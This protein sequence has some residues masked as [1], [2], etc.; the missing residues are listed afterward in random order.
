MAVGRTKRL[1][2][3]NGQIP[4]VIARSL[5]FLTMSFKAQGVA[6]PK[7]SLERTPY[8]QIAK[9]LSLTKAAMAPLLIASALKRPVGLP[10][11]TT[12]ILTDRR[13]R[14]LC[15]PFRLLPWLK[16]QMWHAAPSSRRALRTATL[17]L[18]VRTA[19]SGMKKK[20]F[21]PIPMRCSSFL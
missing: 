17:L 13:T 3:R 15:A 5:S 12:D 4:L 10:R 6:P 21:P 8:P 9:Q 20:L 19:L 7:V 18:T 14:R 2:P 1:F 11:G 16:L